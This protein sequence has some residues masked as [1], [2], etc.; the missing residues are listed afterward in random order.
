VT[1]YEH[2]LL[3]LGT[4]GVVGLPW[5]AGSAR[6]DAVYTADGP[7]YRGLAATI[8]SAAVVARGRIGV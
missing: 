8:G 4:G 7:L 2:D 6:T 1:G 5:A 3:G